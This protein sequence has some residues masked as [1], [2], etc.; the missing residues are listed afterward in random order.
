MKYHDQPIVK[1]IEV[2]EVEFCRGKGTSEDVVRRITAYF[3][4][5]GNL[6]AEYDPCPNGVLERE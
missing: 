2:V 1:V 5:E 3:D 4:F 6:L